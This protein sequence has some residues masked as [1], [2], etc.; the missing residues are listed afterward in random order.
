[1]KRNVKEV[2]FN[3]SIASLTADHQKKLKW[4]HEHQ[5]LAV[6]WIEISSKKL[7][8]IPKGIYKPA[9]WVY[10]LSAKTTMSE[11]YDDGTIRMN[12]DSSWEQVNCPEKPK[13]GS[14]AYTNKALIECAKDFVPIGYLTQVKQKPSTYRV[15]GPALVEYKE[16]SDMFNLIGCSSEGVF[17]IF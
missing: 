16:A 5:N 7:A 14:Y 15:M 9:E 6:S 10:A 4:F 12:D 1:M 8:I 3:E 2:Y 17:S 13:D 11:S